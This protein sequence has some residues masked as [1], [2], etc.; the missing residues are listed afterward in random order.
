MPQFFVIA[1]F[2]FELAGKVICNVT[3]HFSFANQFFKQCFPKNSFPFLPSM[4][5]TCP[6]FGQLSIKGEIILPLSLPIIKFYF[7]KYLGMKYFEDFQS[8][9][10]LFSCGI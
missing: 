9:F 5:E 4:Y 3:M 7:D 2:T 1:M 6:S 8:Q 10:N